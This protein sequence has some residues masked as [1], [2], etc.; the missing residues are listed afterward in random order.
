MVHA[1]SHRAHR[2]WNV[3]VSTDLQVGGVNSIQ[4]IVNHNHVRMAVIVLMRAVDLDVIAAEL[5]ILAKR[6]KMTLMNA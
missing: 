1:S 6:V 3:S 2:E 4:T 5:V